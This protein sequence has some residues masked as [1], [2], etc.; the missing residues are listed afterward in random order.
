M[1]TPGVVVKGRRNPL[2]ESDRRLKE[3]QKS[4][5][6]LNSDGKRKKSVTERAVDRVHKYTSEHSDP[7]K[8]DDSSKA[9]LQ[10][11]QNPLDREHQGAPGAPPSRD[12]QD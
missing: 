9:F 7:N 1:E 12:P 10:Q 6:D 11:T 2:S 5:P 3:V 4:L 8:L